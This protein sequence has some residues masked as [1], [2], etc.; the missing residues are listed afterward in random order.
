MR[1]PVLIVYHNAFFNFSNHFTQFIKGEFKGRAAAEKLA[2][3]STKSV[4]LANFIDN[5]L[6]IELVLNIKNSP[7]SFM[8][9]GGNDNKLYKMFHVTVKISDIN[10]TCIKIQFFNMSLMIECKA[11]RASDDF[12]KIADLFENY[13]ISNV[14]S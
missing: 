9:D 3:G 1:M 5:H 4:A 8:V 11:S 12:Q 13:N 7:F 14:S 6:K 2:C 10:F